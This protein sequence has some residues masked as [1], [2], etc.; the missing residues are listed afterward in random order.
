MVVAPSKVSEKAS[1]F[2]AVVMMDPW[3]Q[4]GERAV[5]GRRDQLACGVRVDQGPDRGR[6]RSERRGD[7][8]NDIVADSASRG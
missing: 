8:H 2:G 7:V 3:H 4:G 1:V 6:I 5:R